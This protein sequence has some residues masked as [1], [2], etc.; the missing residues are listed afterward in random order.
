MTGTLDELAPLE[1]R[2]KPKT[3]SRP[4]YKS[5]LLEQRKVTRERALTN[6]ERIITGGHLL[7]NGIDTIEC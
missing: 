3:K 4:W 2:G 7:G 6:T 1:D 5:Q